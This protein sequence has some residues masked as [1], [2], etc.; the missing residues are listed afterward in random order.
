MCTSVSPP[1]HPVHSQQSDLPS[2]VVP[3][4]LC[5]PWSLC[6]GG[7]WCCLSTHLRRGYLG[8]WSAGLGGTGE[9]REASR[10]PIVPSTKLVGTPSITEPP[11][12]NPQPCFRTANHHD[13]NRDIHHTVH[14]EK[15]HACAPGL[16]RDL[17][18]LPSRAKRPI[19]SAWD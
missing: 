7:C 15:T 16:R 10:Q 17:V 5:C 2:K 4:Y 14:R 1:N 9:P 11:L 8:G 19:G 6:A 3:L 18:F 12:P 13:S